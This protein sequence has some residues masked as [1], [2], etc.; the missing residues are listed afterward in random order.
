MAPQRALTLAEAAERLRVTPQRISQM[1]RCGVLDGPEVAPGRA[2][3]YAPRVW[4]RSLQQEITRR[5]ETEQYASPSRLTRGHGQVSKRP[6]PND[7]AG[8]S[9]REAA[10]LEAALLMKLRLDEARKA[11][12]E[13]RQ[14]N[15]R[16]ASMLAAVTAELQAAQEQTE[17]LDDIA[18]GYSDALTQLLIP[19]PASSLS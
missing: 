11:L 2:Q 15:K 13:E 5:E 8:P 7:E 18:A 12:R 1:L 19:D 14:A 3:K 6:E 4:E 10:A 16:L 9:A 17:R